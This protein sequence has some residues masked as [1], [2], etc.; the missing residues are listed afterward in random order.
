MKTLYLLRHG[1]AEDK[2]KQ[3][4]ISRNLHEEGKE[5]VK[6]TIENFIRQHPV[7]NLI[8]S[9]HANRAYQTAEIAAKMM[10][11]NPK[12]IE[13]ENNIYYSDT[14]A[15]R[16]ALERQD[17]KYQ[18]ILLTGHNP[19]TTWFASQLNPDYKDMMPTGGLVAFEINTNSWDSLS[20]SE[21]KLL[22]HIYP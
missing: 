15:M 20:K 2:I 11:Y 22:F 9:S 4:D 8:I 21:A 16:E 1:H 12:N 18:S 7:P 19:T 10:S 5:E 6:L 17:D 3:P 14:E 13:L